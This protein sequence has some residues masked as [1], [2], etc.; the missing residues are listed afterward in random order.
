MRYQFYKENENDRIWWAFTPD[1]TGVWLFS[2]DQ[3][4]VFNMFE[5]TKILDHVNQ[6]AKALWDELEAIKADY[7]IV[8]GHRGLG[9]MQGLEFSVPAGQIVKEV[10]RNKCILIS[11]STN[12]IRFVPPLIVEECH[13]KKMAECLR[14]ALDTV[15]AAQ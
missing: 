15:S 4:T 12:I 1:V 10:I 3:K 11:A 9:L 6:I 13:I 2:F 7:P 8:T 5:E 14:K